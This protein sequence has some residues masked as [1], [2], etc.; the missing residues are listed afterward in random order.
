MSLPLT[1]TVA[2]V[3]GATSGIGAATAAGLAARGASLVLIGRRADR[4]AAQASAIEA[5][6][7][8]VLT[9]ASDVTAA[10]AP[11]RVVDAAGQRFGRIDVLVNNAGLMLLG[12][13]SGAS[14]G[15]WRRMVD[16]NLV[17][18]M[19]LTRAALP[20]L[21]RAAQDDPRRVA[22]IV[23]VSS[24]AGRTATAGSSGYNATKFAV[25][26]FTEAL[27]Q[28]VTAAYV[29]VTAIEPG[30]VGTELATHNPAPVRQAIEATYGHL[31]LLEAGDV[32]DAI[33]YAVTRPRHVSVNELLIRP[34]EQVR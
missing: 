19:E 20:A 22:D 29:R 5:N 25:N 28:E 7:G 21:T 32:A 1:G 30:A 2:L 14:A 9:V 23:N 18:L 15:D 34:T 4:L 26:G 6:G 8:R 33:S 16:T 13:V 24:V 11:S 3:T 17:A 10:D 27:R 31:T 12:P